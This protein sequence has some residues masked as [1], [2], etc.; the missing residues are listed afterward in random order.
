[1]LKLH[2]YLNW[3]DKKLHTVFFIDNK[4]QINEDLLFDFSDGQSVTVKQ[5]L[6]GVQ[7]KPAAKKEVDTDGAVIRKTDNKLLS[8]HEFI[9]G[10]NNSLE[11][12]VVNVNSDKDFPM[13]GGGRAPKPLPV[14]DTATIIKDPFMNKNV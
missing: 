12:D 5:G 3:A 7:K 4:D 2:K 6:I 11:S 1:L 8:H 13:L 9:F 10:K 14:A